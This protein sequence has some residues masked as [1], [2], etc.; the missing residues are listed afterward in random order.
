MTNKGLIESARCLKGTGTGR[1]GGVR[2]SA[3]AVLLELVLPEA[4]EGVAG[5]QGGPVGGQALADGL[6]PLHVERL[7]IGTVRGVPTH[8]TH[9]I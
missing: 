6:E 5:V 3:G 7:R 9:F 4:L 2:S 8:S 1:E